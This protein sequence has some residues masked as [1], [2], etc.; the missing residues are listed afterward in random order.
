MTICIRLS[1]ITLALTVAVLGCGAVAF[2][3]PSITLSPTVTDLPSLGKVVQSSPSSTAVFRIDAA[4]GSVTRTSGTL[5]R[6]GSGSVTTPSVTVSCKNGPGNGAPDRCGTQGNLTSVTTTITR[7]TSS[8]SA[9]LSAMN[10]SVA[11]GSGVTCQSP[12]GQNSASASVTCSVP[13]LVGPGATETIVT[14]KVGTD[15]TVQSAS[16]SG[17]ITLNYT[18]STNP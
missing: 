1:P 14:I 11:A 6:I 17:T 4:T 5:T 9:F 16:P 3:A 10:I 2:A 18:V 7:V 15:T 12:V 13:N 8:G